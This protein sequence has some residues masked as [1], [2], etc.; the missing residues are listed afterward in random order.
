V[1]HNIPTADFNTPSGMELVIDEIKTFNKGLQPIGKPYWLSS[2][3]KRAN[4]RAGSIV[5]AFATADEA[6]RAI[7][8]RLF[9]AGISVRVE[10][11]YATA[12][13][14]QCGKCQAFGHIDTYCKRN[15]PKCKL[16]GEGHVTQQH[17]CNT[18]NT[19]GAKCVHLVP[20]CANCKGNHTADDRICE[21]F[22]SIK[23]T[24]LN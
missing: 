12:P 4:Q 19:K 11:F 1:L 24:K 8:H 13:T 7:R 6:S 14:T 20:S 21:V 3:D 16:C 18:C 10:K 5:V 17:A 2:A 9:I 23:S 15:K 22:T